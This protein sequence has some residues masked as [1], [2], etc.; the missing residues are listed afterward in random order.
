MIDHCLQEAA[1]SQFPFY[2]WSIGVCWASNKIFHCCD[3]ATAVGLT[4][5]FFFQGDIPID[6]Q[7]HTL[8]QH[9][10]HAKMKF[11]Q[12]HCDN[13]EINWGGLCIVVNTKWAVRS[14]VWLRLDQYATTPN[15]LDRTLD[16]CFGNVPRALVSKPRPPLGLCNRNFILLLP[17]YWQKQ[18]TKKHKQKLG[19]FGAINSK[20][21][22]QSCVS[23]AEWEVL[24]PRSEGDLY[25]LTVEGLEMEMTWRCYHSSYLRGRSHPNEARQPTVDYQASGDKRCET[26]SKQ[27]E[28]LAM[29]GRLGQDL[30][31]WWA[32]PRHSPPFSASTQPSLKSI[33]TSTAT[34]STIPVD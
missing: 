33:Q 30:T 11:W 22:A 14:T 32:E 28:P 24:L 27:Q 3:V 29:Q 19:N 8:M 13:A 4:A 25:L 1:S 16:L 23:I 7:L 18:K 2:I 5:D 31:P 9:F 20:E 34:S 6:N 10:Y 17:K 12:G 26:M 21:S 15:A